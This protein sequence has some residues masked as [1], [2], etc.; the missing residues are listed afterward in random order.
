LNEHRARVQQQRTAARR[1]EKRA[2]AEAEGLPPPES[3]DGDEVVLQLDAEG[4]IVNGP[5]MTHEEIVETSPAEARALLALVLTR[6]DRPKLADG[7]LKAVVA[8]RDAGRIHTPSAV[9]T[10]YVHGGM[11]EGGRFARLGE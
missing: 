6:V 8:A 1:A 11:G 9:A 2:L 3:D 4:M 10:M 7:Y 5:P